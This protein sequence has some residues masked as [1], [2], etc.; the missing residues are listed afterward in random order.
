[1][2][3]TL[4]PEA[5][6]SQYQPQTPRG[7][8]QF[9]AQHP[10]GSNVL[11]TNEH[12]ASRAVDLA[13]IQLQKAS[14]DREKA[15]SVPNHTSKS[16]IASQG[17][18]SFQDPTLSQQKQQQ[19]QQQQQQ[20]IGPK[21]GKKHQTH[22]DTIS[23][24]LHTHTAKSEAQPKQFLNN[25][26]NASTFELQ[27]DVAAVIQTKA[28][29]HNSNG[30][31]LRM[32]PASAMKSAVSC[33]HLLDADAPFS[34]P[35]TEDLNAIQYFPK[36]GR[37][38]PGKFAHL[39]MRSDDPEFPNAK[40]DRDAIN[41]ARIVREQKRY[42]KSSGAT[43]IPSAKDLATN[44]KLFGGNDENDGV[45]DITR[46]KMTQG[47]LRGCGAIIGPA[48]HTLQEARTATGNLAVDTDAH[49]EYGFGGNLQQDAIAHGNKSKNN[50]SHPEL[51]YH[52]SHIP[53]AEFGRSNEEK[54]IHNEFGYG[55]NDSNDAVA[56]TYR[57]RQHNGSWTTD[58]GYKKRSIRRPRRGLN[59]QAAAAKSSMYNYMKPTIGP[60]LPPAALPEGY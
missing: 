39:F 54:N 43:F 11:H 2:A 23:A 18:L 32:T 60:Q 17:L 29:T 52:Q 38:T 24:V 26:R 6:P 8:L 1:M 50:R 33:I 53:S 9:K 20:K 49:N 35:R 46:Y 19:Q 31:G 22:S 41:P 30:T 12:W 5:I 45:A 51:F 14:Q 57:K 28:E 58:S 16:S 37:R 44:R 42:K 3:K 7:K 59:R 48:P 34:D 10:I 13:T 47:S 4:A 56:T 27:A 15:K 21:R 55:G 36:Y 40:P 25:Q